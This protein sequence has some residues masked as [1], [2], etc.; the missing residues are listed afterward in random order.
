MP[1]SILPSAA[2]LLFLLFANALPAEEDPHSLQKI[3]KSLAELEDQP[4]VVHY[5]LETTVFWPKGSQNMVLEGDEYEANRRRKL[6]EEMKAKNLPYRWEDLGQGV[7][8]PNEDITLTMMEESI[9]DLATGKG[10]SK[11][12]KEA[13][14]LVRDANDLPHL[15]FWIEPFERAF[16]GVDSYSRIDPERHRI[17]DTEKKIRVPT[18]FRIWRISAERGETTP[19]LELLPRMF[20]EG[21]FPAPKQPYVP[22]GIHWPFLVDRWTRGAEEADPEGHPII[23]SLPWPAE[24][25]CQCSLRQDLHYVPGKWQRFYYDQLTEELEIEY[26]RVSDGM[27][28]LQSWKYRSFYKGKLYE[29]RTFRVLRVKRENSV[30]PALFRIAPPDGLIVTEIRTEREG[31]YVAGRKAIKGPSEVEVNDKLLLHEIRFQ[32]LTRIFAGCSLLVGSLVVLIWRR[33][34]RPKSEPQLREQEVPA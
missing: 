2:T 15:K 14:E 10:Y 21:G 32:W 1:R 22:S 6:A 17:K 3:A 7:D 5:K 19:S 11:G 26:E 4:P 30:D 27:P 18:G 12:E 25:H 24:I 28:V 31:S 9:R 16:D 29:M 8:I 20:C 23:Y 33:F 34:R 13:A